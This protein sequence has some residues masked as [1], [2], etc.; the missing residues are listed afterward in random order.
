M[1]LTSA[2]SDPAVWPVWHYD[3]VSA[4]RRTPTLR[5][6]GDRFVLSDD[7]S[8]AD[9]DSATYAFPDLVAHAPVGGDAVFGL[10]GRPGWR[11]GFQGG[12]PADLATLLP[13]A[14]RYG[15]P[16]DRFG[17]WRSV[18]VLAVIAGLALYAFAQTPALVARLVPRA[19]ERQL[20]DVMVGDFGGRL[21]DNPASA[22]A[23]NTLVRRLGSDP[24]EVRIGIANIP[25]VN[26]VT[27][28]GGRILVF[29]GL[30]KNAA[31]ADEVAG[32]VGHELGHFAH[33]DVLE[34]L[35]R[36]LGLSVL[37]GG[38]EGNIGGY[39]N[40]L[41]STAYSRRAE[42]SADDYAINALSTAKIDPVATAGFFRR[43]GGNVRKP[44]QSAVVLNYLATHPI[45]SDRAGKFDAAKRPEAA[46]TPA[47]TEAQWHAVRTACK[48]V[49][50]KPF[51]QFGF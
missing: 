12:P 48:G 13:R 43:L 3:G 7:E 36:Q 40:A 1:P 10:A 33:R 32:V 44:S 19:L 49:A 18:L 37:L 17:L 26:A 51:T 27:L 11:I 16:I 20:G 47:L 15:G 39:T 6:E 2:P 8:E 9:G 28:P 46:Y 42:T 31:S 41:L 4:I 14:A 50:R 25:V 22:A 5:V 34:S 35:L 23:L 45:A 29:E 24:A 38:L 21:C 30:L